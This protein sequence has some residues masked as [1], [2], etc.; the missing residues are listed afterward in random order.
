[1]IMLD[2]LIKDKL[3]KS[4]YLIKLSSGETLIGL[5]INKTE[6]GISVYFPYNVEF[7]SIYEHCIESFDRRFEISLYHCAYIK[8]PSIKICDKFFESVILDQEVAFREFITKFAAVVMDDEEPEEEER[9]F[10]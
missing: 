9:V 4:V 1:M 3:Y 5:V 2:E 8:R 7:G 6:V 10:H